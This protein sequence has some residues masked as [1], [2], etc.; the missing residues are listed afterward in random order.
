MKRPER[1]RLGS[2]GD[3]LPRALAAS[4]AGDGRWRRLAGA[5]AAAVGAEWGVQAWIALESPAPGA[6]AVSMRTSPA[7]SDWGWGQGATVEDACA[8]LCAALTEDPG[9]YPVLPRA[10]RGASSLEELELRLAV[11]GGEGAR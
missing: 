9:P 5:L 3:A 11:F 6:C 8:D 2:P 10:L 7:G 4:G 1:F